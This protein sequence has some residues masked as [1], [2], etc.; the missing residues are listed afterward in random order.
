MMG[1]WIVRRRLSRL[2]AWGFSLRSRGSNEASS[3]SI[4]R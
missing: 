2:Q 4:T 1:T 3:V